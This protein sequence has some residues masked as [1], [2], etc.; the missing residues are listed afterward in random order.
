MS[1]KKKVVAS[2]FGASMAIGSMGAQAVT[3]IDMTATGSSSELINSALLGTAPPNDGAG[4][5]AV[6]AFLRT[7]ADGYERGFNTDA[8]VPTLEMDQ[9]SGC[10]THSIQ[11]GDLRSLTVDGADYFLFAL[12]INESS[13]GTG[14]LISLHELEIYVNGSTASPT[15][16]G[17]LGTLVWNMDQQEETVVTMENGVGGSFGGGDFDYF[18]LVPTA[19]FA[20]ASFTDYIYLYNEF[21]LPSGDTEGVYYASDAGHEEWAAYT[22][23]VPVPAAVWLF[24]SGLIGLVGLARRKKA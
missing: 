2:L 12:D 16:Y 10:C 23:A 19:F 17:D 7:Q 18:L 24:A 4:S 15:A 5:G 3:I 13:G 6:D 9:V 14:D 22:S 21:G 1:M 8:V 20:K 11:K